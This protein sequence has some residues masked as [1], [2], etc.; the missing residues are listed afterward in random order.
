ML[1][2]RTLCYHLLWKGQVPLTDCLESWIEMG[3]KQDFMWLL[4]HILSSQERLPDSHTHLTPLG[5]EAKFHVLFQCHQHRQ[6]FGNLRV[7]DFGVPK[8]S[9]ES[10]SSGFPFMTSRWCCSEEPRFLFVVCGSLHLNTAVFS[11]FPTH[12][13]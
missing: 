7:T 2:H 3:G 12:Q 4:S 1:A 10:V 5:L 11:S 6:A 9:C 8:I 13:N